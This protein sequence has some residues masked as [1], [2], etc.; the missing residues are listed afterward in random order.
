MSEL[1][2]L[3]FYTREL[4]RHL[5]RHYFQPVPSRL[6]WLI[7]HG[8]VILLG[9]WA[10]ITF[11]LPFIANLGI[12]VA[13]G[14]SFA[15]LG[16]LAHEV[17]HGS[18]VKTPWLRDTIGAICF[19]QFNLGPK[20]W[21]KWHNVEHHGHTQHAG[22][23][24]DA[25]GTLEQYR[26]RPELRFLYAIAP[27]M[28]SLLTFVSFT[29]WF[30]YHGLEMLKRYRK[31]FHGK[32]RLYLYLQYALPLSLWIAL[33]IWIGPAKFTFVYIIPLLISNFTVMSYIATN[34][35]LNP[36]TPINDP[37]A[38]SLTV[39]KPRWMDVLHFNFSHHT[40]HHI[41][42][43]MNPK[44]AP[45]VKALAKQ[46]WGDRYN[47]MPHWK[48]LLSIWKTPRL[49][50]DDSLLADPKRELAYPTLGHG[51][52]PDNLRPIPFKE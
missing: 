24:P 41:F 22:D 51:L 36:L 38:N 7:P 25:M 6:L 43:S 29:F 37:L 20:L 47:E 31:D 8:A 40:E 34:H 16:F 9:M 10:I 19:A 12:S 52:D 46:F 28:R 32:D 44:F 3:R 5:P 18:V 45:K 11:Q 2:H 42:P 26:D 50:R 30:S 27:W 33:L 39:T 4:K 48:S 49:Y 13:I 17:L 35:L 21:R 1:N 23:D 15:A 14:S